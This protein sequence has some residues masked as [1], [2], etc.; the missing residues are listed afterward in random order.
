M[1]RLIVYASR[2][3][4]KQKLDPSPPLG[5]AEDLTRVPLTAEGIDE[6]NQDGFLFF[7]KQVLPGEV[8]VDLIDG[9]IPVTT[10]TDKAKA[11]AYGG[12]I[13]TIDAP[14]YALRSLQSGHEFW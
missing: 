6:L 7:Q 1:G 11:M 8:Q 12:S 3:G 9:S 13:L 4:D 2:H 10:L 14:S 5:S